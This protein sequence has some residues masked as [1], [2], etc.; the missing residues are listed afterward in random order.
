MVSTIE[1][2][3]K[4][5]EL[6]Y[7]ANFMFE[8]L[9]IIMA[10]AI[11]FFS[12]KAYKFTQK[13]NYF[14]LFLSFLLLSIAYLIRIVDNIIFFLR[15]VGAGIMQAIASSQAFYSIIAILYLVL[16]IFS[17]LILLISFQKITNKR[18]VILLYT[19]AFLLVISSYKTIGIFYLTSAVLLF[20]V[21]E[22][23]F[24]NYEKNKNTST[25]LL[26]FSFLLMFI[27]QI[28]SLLFKMGLVARFDNLTFSVLQLV[29]LLSYAIIVATLIRIFQ[30]R[31][32]PEK[33]KKQKIK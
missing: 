26:F 1:F 12:Y 14:Y 8:A 6:F 15:D 24:R 28:L 10:I 18:T 4:G 13:N 19:I 30:R 31:E 25:F 23:L 5:S 2:I 17:Y 32:S 20:F 29:L 27:V 3:W 11:S 22:H 9:F 21:I 16:V 33:V 7:S